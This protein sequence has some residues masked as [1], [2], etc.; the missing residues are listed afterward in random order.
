METRINNCT[1]AEPASDPG[2]WR[3]LAEK[4]RTMPEDV[5]VH[6]GIDSARDA[7]LREMNTL[8]PIVG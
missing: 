4:I 5:A 3:I 6:R 7:M 8:A 2:A 1:L